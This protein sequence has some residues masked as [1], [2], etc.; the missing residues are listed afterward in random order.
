MLPGGAWPE[1]YPLGQVKRKKEMCQAV[2]RW[3]RRAGGSRLLA[4]PILRNRAW[5]GLPSR[6]HLLLSG[7]NPRVK[8]LGLDAKTRAN[9]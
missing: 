3:W 4:T 2:V 6:A 5:L 8:Y 1:L 7:L 9:R